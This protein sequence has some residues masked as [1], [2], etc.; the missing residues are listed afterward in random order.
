MALYVDTTKCCA[1]VKSCGCGCSC[2][3]HDHDADCKKCVDVCPEGAITHSKGII[4]D[5]ELCTECG[6]CVDDCCKGALHLN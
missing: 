1:Y 2:G 4:I 3:A 6:V 5:D